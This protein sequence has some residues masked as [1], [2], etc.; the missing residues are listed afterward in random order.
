MA[1]KEDIVQ[2]IEKLTEYV[3]VQTD[4]IVALK[5]TVNKLYNELNERLGSVELTQGGLKQQV[6]DA[7]FHM[8]SSME[9]LKNKLA[10]PPAPSMAPAPSNSLG[11]S[12]GTAAVTLNLPLAQVLKALLPANATTDP[13]A[14]ALTIN[15]HDPKVLS[16]VE[17]KYAMSTQK[18]N[19]IKEY[20][21][22]TGASLI[23]AKTAIEDW[24]TKNNVSYSSQ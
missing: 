10:A 14:L 18:I 2:S 22:R 13:D 1:T 17:K 8:T 21:A 11:P 24:M 5:D 6:T 7:F 9:L 16:E 19:A 12:I 23:E 3:K 20:R 15:P 4:G